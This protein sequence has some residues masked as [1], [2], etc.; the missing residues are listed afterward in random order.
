MLTGNQA[1][2]LNKVLHIVFEVQVY[3]QDADVQKRVFRVTLDRDYQDPGT[4]GFWQKMRRKT[5]QFF[6]SRETYL[7]LSLATRSFLVHFTYGLIFITQLMGVASLEEA[8]G[9][10][11]GA[12]PFA[13]TTLGVPAFNERSGNLIAGFLLF[14]W[15]VFVALPSSLLDIIFYAT[16]DSYPKEEQVRSAS[17][18]AL[19]LIG[20]FATSPVWS[21]IYGWVPPFKSQNRY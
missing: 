21:C 20:W 13:F 8:A 16:A 2:T 9:T 11:V 14:N 3:F 10:L 12:K 7:T 5:R 18:V 6:T 1:L 19:I 4:E 15:L 17:T